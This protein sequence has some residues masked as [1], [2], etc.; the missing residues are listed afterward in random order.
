[1][2]DDLHRL[3]IFDD[4]EW[5]AAAAD[6]LARRM[7]TVIEARG[8]CSLALSGGSTPAPVFEALARHE[9]DW[10]RVIL[11][12]ADER[13]VPHDAP[14]RN[15]QTQ[16]AAFGDLPVRWLPMP[17]DDLLA[18]RPA[19]N[20]GA[21]PAAPISE[22]SGAV[23]AFVERLH[24]LAEDPVIL[25]IVHLGLGDDGHTASLFAGDPALEVLRDPIAL[26]GIQAGYRRL[27]LTRPVLDR[28]H[29]VFWLVRGSAKVPALGRLLAGDLSIPAGLIRPAHSVVVADDAAAR[30]G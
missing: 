21:D 9:L 7:E 11:L 24:R 23:A 2:G 4:D 17:V 28:A 13:L 20:G 5:A 14:E 25:D 29:C 10:D 27:T 8:H 30:Q 6:L 1:M 3:V 22:C 12:Q 19:L 18:E 15:L 16:Q 26:T